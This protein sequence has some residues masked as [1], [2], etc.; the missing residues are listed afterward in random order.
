MRRR[1][2]VAILSGAAARPVIAGAQR[3]NT[4]DPVLR[5]A[6]L[7]SSFKPIEDRLTA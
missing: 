7:A 5:D 1:A 6:M 3:Q 2:F 4:V